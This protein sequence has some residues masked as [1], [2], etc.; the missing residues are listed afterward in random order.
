MPF[1][2]GGMQDARVVEWLVRPGQAVARGDVVAVVDTFKGAI[3]IE[4]FES[5]VVEELLVDVGSRVAVGAPLARIG[6]GAAAAAAKP[7]PVAPAQPAPSA[8]APPAGGPTVPAVPPAPSA[9]SARVAAT[10]AARLRA[11]E[12]GVDLAAVPPS[13]SGGVIVLADVERTAAA[14]RPAPAPAA[15]A[16]APTPGV[17]PSAPHA[18]RV[19]P[20]ARRVAEE[21][22]VEL[23]RVQGSGPG[24]AVTR[25]DVERA[26]LERRAAARGGPPPASPA[27]AEQAAAE[28]RRAIAAAMSRS[29]R[30]I[31]HYYVSTPIDL[32]R[33]LAW[34]ERRNAELPLARRILPA[35]VLLRAVALALHDVPELNGFWVEDAFRPGPGVHLGVAIALRGGGLVAPAIHDADHRSVDEIMT[36]L[37]DLVTR[38]RTGGL[39]GSEL[40]D[41]TVTVTELGDRGVETVYGIV[42]PPQVALVGFGKIMERPWAEGGL[43]GARPVVV[44]SLAADHRASDGHRGG[45]F[46]AAL[47]HLLQEPEA[48]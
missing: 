29:K 42:N 46:L 8:P 16:A 47:D 6:S 43:V 5:G 27:P 20:L 31:P 2:G 11:S 45:L 18:P 34:L 36:A 17:T 28:M 7:A 38:A 35:A 37:K 22:G 3:E 30:E 12:L 1:L 25:A 44:A 14:A 19:S 10:P 26:D 24:G 41:P 40:S 9:P 13:G 48:L 39:R 23:P 21:L 15:P 4:V 32:S 33:A